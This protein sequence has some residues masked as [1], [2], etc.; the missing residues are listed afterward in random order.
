MNQNELLPWQ[1][2][3][4]PFL[5]LHAPPLINIEPPNKSSIPK[6]SNPVHLLHDHPHPHPR[7]GRFF[8]SG[9]PESAIPMNIREA[10]HEPIPL[11][12]LLRNLLQIPQQTRPRQI[13]R[14]PRLPMCDLLVRVPP[15]QRERHV[16]ARNRVLRRRAD[17]QRQE[18]GI[19]R[20]RALLAGSDVVGECDGCGGEAVR[21]VG[22]GGGGVGGE[23]G[24]DDGG[25]GE[26]EKAAG[27]DGGF[28]ARWDFEVMQWW[29]EESRLYDCR[30]AFRGG[31]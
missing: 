29:V 18:R 19:A 4:L 20:V 22:V 11:H 5:P 13:R 23:D 30:G 16:R 10:L 25:G 12:I 26:G 6:T 15:R 14:R 21:E 7:V 9:Q 3:S 17:G 28:V 1:A 27:E 2:H 8:I 24:G 31:E